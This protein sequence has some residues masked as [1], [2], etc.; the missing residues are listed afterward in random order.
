VGILQGSRIGLW[1]F[2]SVLVSFLDTAAFQCLWVAHGIEKD[3]LT[4]KR[5]ARWH[6]VTLP[7]TCSF[8]TPSPRSQALGGAL[9]KSM[10][11]CRREKE[12]KKEEGKKKKGRGRIA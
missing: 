12:E 10:A 11:V 9:W 4:D 5:H 2:G 7:E 1:T 3:S 6:T 8:L